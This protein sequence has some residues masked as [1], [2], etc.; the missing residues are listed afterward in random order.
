MRCISSGRC[1]HRMRMPQP[2]HAHASTHAYPRTHP[3][4]GFGPALLLLTSTC[5]HTRARAHTHTHGTYSNG[6][7]PN[8]GRNPPLHYAA[9]FGRPQMVQLLLRHGADALKVDG[10]NKTALDQARSASGSG[11]EGRHQDVVKILEAA[12]AA[13]VLSRLGFGVCCVVCIVC[14]LLR[15]P[16]VVLCVNYRRT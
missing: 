12:Q 7:D 1:P 2:M 14:S 15:V 4:P 11:K 10:E 13:Q 9:R 16:A 5:F 8:L 3:P 6:A